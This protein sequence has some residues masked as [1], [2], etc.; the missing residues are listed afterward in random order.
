[1]KTWTMRLGLATTMAMVVVLG[2][3][4]AMAAGV[5]GITD[6]N[7]DQEVLRS[8][9]P[10]LVE[11]TATGDARSKQ[12]NPIIQQV[13]DQTAGKAKVGKLDVDA[14][15]LTAQKYGVR[16]VPH[17][18]VFKKGQKTGAQAGVTDA[19]T[20]RKLLGV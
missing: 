19:A 17:A 11:F 7:F 9:I 20:L 15:P 13:A 3:R 16:A 14:A 18:I 10:V 2:A 12:M 8:P 6:Q 1:M 5:V 4:V